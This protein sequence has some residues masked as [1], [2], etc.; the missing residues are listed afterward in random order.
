MCQA[1][2]KEFVEQMALVD[3]W[4][5]RRCDTHVAATKGNVFIV[6]P[7]ESRAR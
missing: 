1:L 4:A 2:S 6:A 5:H 3:R 7:T